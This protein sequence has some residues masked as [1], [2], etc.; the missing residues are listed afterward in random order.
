MPAQDFVELTADCGND[1]ADNAI[2]V[3]AKNLK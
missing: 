1:D 2:Q 3:S